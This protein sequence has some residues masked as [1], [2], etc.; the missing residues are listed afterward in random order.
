MI[1]DCAFGIIEDDVRQSELGIT[2][3]PH[4]QGK[5]YAKEAITCVLTCVFNNSDIERVVMIINRDN[6]SCIQLV[7][8]LGFNMINPTS[9]F[10]ETRTNKELFGVK[11][12]ELM[13][14]ML[15]DDWFLLS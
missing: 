11:D 5:G 12:N 9:G 15:R 2:L 13:F 4:Y 3:S 10:K 8:N 7:N 1:G 14:S 6:S